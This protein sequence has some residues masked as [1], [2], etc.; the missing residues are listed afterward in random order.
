MKKQLVKAV[1]KQSNLQVLARQ[2]GDK[3][4]KNSPTILTGLGVAG[5]IS[6]TIMA[7]KATPKALT[8]IDDEY[9]NRY[10]ASGTSLDFAQYV[11]DVDNNLT[12]KEI[13]KLTWK[14]Y[15]PTAVMG[16]VTVACF[17][18]ANNINLRRNAALASVYSITEATLKEYQAKVVDT[19]GAPKEQ[20]IKDEI[21]Q[22][23]INRN[24]VSK[25]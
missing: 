17:L 16:T 5:I 9:Y 20:K 1:V 12:K 15:I 13:L 2:I 19:I 10:D 25:K 4:S 7:V 24:P 8:L 11:T 3:M 18:G 21:N 6:T 14:E 22:D 23:N